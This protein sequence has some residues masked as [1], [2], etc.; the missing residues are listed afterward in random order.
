VGIKRGRR[1]RLIMLSFDF[2]QPYGSLLPAKGIVL[3]LSFTDM[4]SKD[5][6]RKELAQVQFKWPQIY[7]FPYHSAACYELLF[8]QC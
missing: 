6:K 2:S 8:I 1:I 7:W 5:E 4:V 3:L